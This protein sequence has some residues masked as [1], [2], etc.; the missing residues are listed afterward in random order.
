MK[1]ISEQGKIALTHLL[2]SA[3]LYVLLLQWQ[4]FIPLSVRPLWKKLFCVFPVLIFPLGYIALPL[5]MSGRCYGASPIG[6]ALMGVF[7]ACNSYLWACVINK[8]YQAV[9][10]KRKMAAGTDAKL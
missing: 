6:V 1:K 4:R 9:K 2:L 7:F 5:G 10:R 8:V 3:S